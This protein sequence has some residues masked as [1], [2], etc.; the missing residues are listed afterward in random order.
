MNVPSGDHTG[1][2]DTVL[3]S[4][5][6]APPSAGILNT[7]TPA[8]SIAPI[9]SHFPSGDQAPA[10]TTASPVDLQISLA[11]AGES[12]HRPSAPPREARYRSEESGPKRGAADRAVGS[13]T[14]LA[15]GSSIGPSVMG[16]VRSCRVGLETRATRRL[17]RPGVSALA[18]MER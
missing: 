11:P 14:R 16:T 13:A 1:L 8:P 5:T 18:A 10:P 4:R 6:G 3:T 7:R 9:A 2:E 12:R 15:A 17:G